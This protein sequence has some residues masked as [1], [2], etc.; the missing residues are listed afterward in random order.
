MQ[1]AEKQC[2]PCKG[3]HEQPISESEALGLLK[4]LPGWQIENG[5]LVMGYE[6]S[7]FAEAV[8]FLDRIAIIASKEEH[9][10]D[11]CIEDYNKMKLSLYTYCCG[12]LTEND[13]ILAAKIGK[14][15]E[16]YVR[17]MR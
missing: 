1:L 12:G 17:E 15:H 10:P 11:V 4:G 3:E 16:G 2:S 7:T 13:F 9:T 5:R 8:S 14:S 6:F